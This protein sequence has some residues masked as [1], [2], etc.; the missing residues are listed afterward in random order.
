[1]SAV[2]KMLGSGE[3]MHAMMTEL[4]PL[5]RS[6]TG[7]GVRRTLEVVSDRVPLEIHEIPSG[8]NVLDW[9]VPDEWNIRDAYVADSSG[10][11]V[12]DFRASNLHVV[13]YSEPIHRRVPLDELRPHLHTLP[14]SP[15]W[16]PYRTSYYERNWGF[17]LSQEQ[18]DALRDP[19]YDVRIDSTLEPGS[20]T[21]GEHLLPGS[22]SEEILLVTHVCHPSLAN[23]NLSGIALLTELAVEL[24]ARP[25]R[26]SYRFLFIPAT[27]G[28]ITWLALNEDRLAHVVG[29]IVLACVGDS[30]PLTYKRSRGGEALIDRAGAHVVGRRDGRVLDFVPW[31][32][33]ERQFNSPGF[34]LPVGCLMRSTEG[35]YAE[36]HSSADDL[37]LVGPEQL[38]DSLAAALEIL[39][40][41]ELCTTYVNLFP[42]GEPQLGR[43]G[44]YRAV[45]GP[46]PGEQQ[47]ATLWVLN[48]SDGSASLLDIAERSGLSVASLAHAAQRLLEAGLVTTARD[49]GR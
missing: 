47:L 11:R 26:L 21:Y 9:T 7:D 48:Q 36:Y 29:G 33:D 22:R 3:R 35:G 1:M 10:T 43:R 46:D 16:I 12:V 6:I 20:L 32:W 42:K 25:R 18:F 19:A 13:S 30:A 2:A 37:S 39:D 38:E 24:A 8:T 41:V 34:A 17:C 27:I 23:D 5:C 45:G 49:A 14:E 31:G 40:V 28:S 15:G 44:L 4:F